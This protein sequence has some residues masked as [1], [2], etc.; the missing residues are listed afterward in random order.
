MKTLLSLILPCA[1]VL[2]T[3]CGSGG[4]SD[5]IPSTLMFAAQESEQSDYEPW[6]TDGTEAGTF[7]LK[8]INDAEGSSPQYPVKL[9]GKWLFSAEDDVHG[10]ELWVSDETEAGTQLLKDINTSGNSGARYMTLFKGKVYFTA[11]DGVNGAE[12]WVT[13]GT[14]AGTQMY[15]DLYTGADGSYPYG[16]VVSGGYLYFLADSGDGRTLWATTGGSENNATAR[17]SMTGNEEFGPS[18]YITPY[19]NG[20]MLSAS[21]DAYG[22]EPYFVSG[23]RAKRIGDIYPSTGSSYSSRFYVVNDKV[24]FVA[25]DDEHGRELWVYDGTNAPQLLSDLSPGVDDTSFSG[26]KVL[27]N[28]LLFTATVNDANRPDSSELELF[29]TKGNV[30]DISLVKGGS[31]SN[32]FRILAATRNTVFLEGDYQDK[33]Y[34]WVSKGD[35]G[36]T[37]PLTVGE[38]SDLV[39]TGVVVNDRFIFVGFNETYGYE[40]WV[41]DGTVAGTKL[42]KDISLDANSSYPELILSGLKRR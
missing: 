25:K 37:I 7:K 26:F 24:V 20:L 17:V 12:L 13:D 14:A 1:A 29:A 15:M 39:P 9:N 34:L 27:N 5:P 21:S 28:Q 2:L 6:I 19:R 22:S 33:S 30:N 3:A 40:L 32:G 31:D 35:T 8:E 18:S 23:L 4:K 10:S 16:L 38:L 42:L 36:S 11:D 41:S